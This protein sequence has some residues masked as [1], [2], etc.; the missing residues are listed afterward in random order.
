MDSAAELLNK[1]QSTFLKERTKQEV[2]VA[3]WG[4]DLSKLDPLILK[5]IE[6][7]SEIT[8]QQLI[9]E[10]YED[11]PNEAVYNAQYAKA[12]QLLQQVNEVADRYNREAIQCLQEFNQM[13]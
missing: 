11:H 12:V 8:L 9:P 7:P 4:S 1:A 3:A 2:A 5:D 6:L 13:N 10:L